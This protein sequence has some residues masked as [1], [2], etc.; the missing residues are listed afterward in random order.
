MLKLTYRYKHNYNVEQVFIVRNYEIVLGR[1]KVTSSSLQA[2]VL[3]DPPPSAAGN[4]EL[5]PQASSTELIPTGR[6]L[7]DLAPDKAV[8]QRHARLFYDLSTWWVEDLGSKNKTWLN[9]H[10]I[11][12]HQP[13]MLT[14]GDKLIIGETAILIDFTPVVAEDEA[15]HELSLVTSLSIRDSQEQEQDLSY[16]KTLLLNQF[17]DLLQHSQGQQSLLDLVLI[18]LG[19]I[20]PQAALRSILL[21]EGKEL[22]PRVFY[23]T[24]RARVSFRLARQVLLTR[25]IMHWQY[26]TGDLTA[27]NSRMD[28]LVQ[29]GSAL[30]SPIVCNGE[31]LGV[32]HLAT[33]SPATNFSLEDVA[34]VR[35]LTSIIAGEL[36]NRSSATL[37]KLPQVFLSYA[38]EDRPQIDR[39]AA[40]LRK[41]RIKVWYDSL[42]EGGQNWQQHIELALLSCD[43]LLTVIS[44]HSTTSPYVQAEVKN[45]LEQGK[46]VIPLVYEKSE[47]P[48]ALQHHQYLHIGDEK[49]YQNSLEELVKIIKQ[50]FLEAVS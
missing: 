48:L 24:D 33:S 32:I 29:P 49:R 18:Y 42:L 37:V 47:L 6:S 35:A 20:F 40:D 11:E 3:S 13:A 26:Q 46:L 23:P 39:L 1:K 19:I 28:S 27:A 8:S 12:P 21:V 4:S 2:K 34:L 44:P 22:V 45:A 30:Y 17:V 7:L 14:P 16:P 5:N 9:G 43:V 31:G 38:R 50:R 25:Q 15:T 36:K 10:F 41:H